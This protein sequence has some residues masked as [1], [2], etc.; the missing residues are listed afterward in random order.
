M[1][2]YNQFIVD[3]IRKYLD[4]VNMSFY[5]CDTWKTIFDILFSQEIGDK[6]Y[7]K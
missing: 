6:F 5:S 2:N 3:S 7:G 4:D 1:K